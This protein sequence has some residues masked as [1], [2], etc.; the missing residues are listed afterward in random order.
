M[1]IVVID[2]RPGETAIGPQGPAGFPGPQGIS[3]FSIYS[4]AGAPAALFGNNGDQYIN[5]TTGQLFEKAAGAW[6]YQ[7]SLIGPS[8]SVG[9]V[10]GGNPS[11]NYGGTFVIDGGIP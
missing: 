6:V 2:F 9:Q 4:D 3:G 5:T 7:S 1:P 11:S 10:D 8:F